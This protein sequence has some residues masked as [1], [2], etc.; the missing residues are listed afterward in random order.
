MVF[1]PK[2]ETRIFFLFR[3]LQV[4]FMTFDVKKKGGAFGL[5]D[6]SRVWEIGDLASPSRNQ[7]I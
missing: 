7:S 6:D 2:I 1:A 3:R 4:P 5:R